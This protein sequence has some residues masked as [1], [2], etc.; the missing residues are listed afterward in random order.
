MRSAITMHCVAVVGRL[1][2]RPKLRVGASY[3][4]S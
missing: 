3:R 1:V 4:T 2:T